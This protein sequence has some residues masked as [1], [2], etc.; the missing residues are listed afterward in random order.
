MFSKLLLN[1]CL[2]FMIVIATTAIDTSVDTR[3][4]PRNYSLPFYV[5]PIHYNIELALR[6][7]TFDGES[8]I[9]IEILQQVTEISLHAEMLQI[10]FNTIL[11]SKHRRKKQEGQ[12]GGRKPWAFTYCTETQILVLKFKEN[13]DAGT[14]EL[15]MKFSGS[16][17]GP[18]GLVAISR[19]IN[20]GEVR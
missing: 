2:I 5:Y 1:T 16:L 4:C 6:D 15:S 14:Y 13:I 11:L 20:K 19:T 12:K 3:N 9:I 7:N 8:S 17:L 18:K 10:D